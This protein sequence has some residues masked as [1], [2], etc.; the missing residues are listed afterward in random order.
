MVEGE[1]GTIGFERRLELFRSVISETK[2]I[3]CLRAFWEKAG[4]SLEVGNGFIA[5]ALL[6]Q[7]FTREHRA[8]AGRGAAAEV[9]P[10]QHQRKEPHKPRPI[11]F[12]GQHLGWW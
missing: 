3:P 1:R 10:R 12:V 4:G 6:N 11:F 9:Q 7:F 8:L 2:V 5:L